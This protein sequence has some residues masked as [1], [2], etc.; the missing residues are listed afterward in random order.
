MS[1]EIESYCGS[2]AEFHA[3]SIPVDPVRR[4]WVCR[5][6]RPAIAIGSAQP[7]DHVD[8]AACSRLGVELVRRRSG[9]GAVL[10]IPGEIVWIDVILPA[11]DPLWEHDISRSGWWLGDIWAA[12]G[13]RLTGRPDVAV[14][15]R[16]LV[17]TPWSAQVCFAGLGPGEVTVGAADVGA[18]KLVGV[19]QRRT[20]T[21]AR[22]Q[23]AIHRVWD[24]VRLGDLLVAPPADPGELGPVAVVDEPIDTI[25]EAFVDQ[26]MTEPHPARDR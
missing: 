6:D 3:R 18:A 17:H 16:G 2:A 5:V 21:A 10:L 11:G 25:I 13:R 12:V 23:T 7:A 9:G 20:R 15:R 19:S 26:L 1:W 22:F 8:A 24:P 4:V 14:H